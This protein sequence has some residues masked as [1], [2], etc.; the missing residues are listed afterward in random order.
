MTRARQSLHPLSADVSAAGGEEVELNFAQAI[1]DPAKWSDEFPNL[2]TLVV[3]LA[4]GNTVTE[5]ESTK[6]GFRKVELIDGAICL[7]GVA[8]EIKGVN[9]H[10]HDPDHGHTVSE[11][12]M[13]R[14]IL[15]M[16]RYNFNA[17]RTSH[18]PS[19]PRWYELCD[20][21]G[22]LALRRGQ[23]RDPRRLGQA[24]QGSALEGSLCRPGRAPGRARQEPPQRHLLV[25]GQRVGLWSQP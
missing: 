19:V 15:I 11:A 20:E 17:V 25:A 21:Y 7:N 8:L 13:V 9:R 4:D 14:D 1:A 16:K 22:I 23:H 6:V 2:Y 5:Y 24:D 3:S 18:Y 12:N 10:E